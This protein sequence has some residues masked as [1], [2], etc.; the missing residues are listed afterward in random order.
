MPNFFTPDELRALLEGHS[1]QQMMFTFVRLSPS[2]SA[3]CGGRT[4]V[5]LDEVHEGDDSGDESGKPKVHD[6]VQTL[7]RQLS[8]ADDVPL[9]LGSDKI[10]DPSAD[11]RESNCLPWSCSIS[12]LHLCTSAEEFIPPELVYPRPLLLCFQTSQAK[13]SHVIVEINEE[14]SVQDVYNAAASQL[15]IDPEQVL[16]VSSR[17]NNWLTTEKLFPRLG[18]TIQDPTMCMVFMGL[19]RK[20]PSLDDIPPQLREKILKKQQ[21][22]AEAKKLAEESQ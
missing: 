15:E 20:K 13:K 5:L 16:M 4:T 18:K 10:V 19:L 6:V 14:S 12:M 17:G 2:V 1:P 22:E 8:L 7:R 3:L 11:A 21:K 9:V